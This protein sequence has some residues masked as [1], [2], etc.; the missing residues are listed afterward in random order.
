MSK[1]DQAPSSG[2]PDPAK[3]SLRSEAVETTL[4][5]I[6]HELRTP[7]GAIVS[8]ADLMKSEAFGPL[9][10]T[11][12]G[13]YAASIAKSAEFA[14][15]VVAQTIADLEND[16]EA[17]TMRLVAVD[18]NGVIAKSV[19]QLQ[20]WADDAGV[21]LDTRLAGDQLLVRSDAVRLQQII[22]NAAMNA[23]KFSPSG[24]HVTLASQMPGRSRAIIEVRDQ[25][26]GM[27]PA[28]LASVRAN[29]SDHGQGYKLMHRLSALADAKLAVDSQRGK[30]TLVRIEL[31]AISDC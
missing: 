10:D 6:A 11:R 27:G 16:P 30:G 13:E 9:G 28:L 2:N 15:D 21:R 7:I 3:R 8:S 19:E 26:L 1:D 22:I 24:A 17:G 18:A 12:Y 4:R 20:P 29:R 23:L 14:L 25:G 31:T 5:R